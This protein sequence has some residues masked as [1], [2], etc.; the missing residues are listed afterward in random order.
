MMISRY[1]PLLAR[2]RI[3]NRSRDRE[4]NDISSVKILS[5]PLRAMVFYK[6]KNLP[7]FGKLM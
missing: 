6:L 2:P 1:L 4:K 5:L 3:A 7:H